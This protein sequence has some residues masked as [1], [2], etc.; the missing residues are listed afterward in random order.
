MRHFRK[1]RN[2]G[3]GVTLLLAL[4]GA[5]IAVP[6][7]AH[8]DPLAG[9]GSPA[10]NATAVGSSIQ[11][12]VDAEGTIPLA[13]PVTECQTI[14]YSATLQ[15]ITNPNATLT[16]AAFEQGRWDLTLPSGVV[17]NLL[18]QLPVPYTQIPCITIADPTRNADDPNLPGGRGACLTQGLDHI[19]SNLVPYTV[20][21]ADIDQNGFI[22]ARANYGNLIP[23]DPGTA[24]AHIGTNDIA[25]VAADTPYPIFVQRCGVSDGCTTRGCDPTTGCFETPVVC[26]DQNSCTADTCDPATGCVFTP[27]VCNDQNACTADTCDPATGCV[28]TPIV[29]NDHNACTTDTCDPATGCV[30]TPNPPCNDQNACTTDTC[31]PATG[32]V[33]TPNPPCNDQNA[34]TTDTCDPAT[35][36][37]FTPNP[38]CNDQNAC[39]TDTCDPATGCV[40]TP[41]VCDDHN[42]C[43]D[44][45]CDPATGCF[46]HCEPEGKPECTLTIGDFIWNDINADGLQTGESSD[47][48]GGV[49]L[50]LVNCA[51]NDTQTT[52]T[53]AD[54]SYLFSVS[55]NPET[56]VFDQNYKIVVT[57]TGNVL[58][59]FTESPANVGTDDTIDSDCVDR[60]IPCQPYT[61]TDLTEDCGFHKPGLVEVC[62]TPGFWGTHAGVE[63]KNSQNITQAVLDRAGG[64]R[65]CGQLIDNTLPH[66]P[67]LTVT[68]QES[69]VEAICVAPRGAQILQLARQL[70]AAALNC[71]MSLGTP[72]PDP[73]RI[74][75][76]TNPCGGVSI[77]DLWGQ[78]DDLCAQNGSMVMNGM[79]V[80]GCIGAL[81]CF[82]NGGLWMDGQCGPNP[83]GS[84]HNRALCQVDVTGMPVPGGLC[85]EPPGAAGSS[86]ACN[87]ATVNG[88]TIFGG[89]EGRFPGRSP[90]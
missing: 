16:N 73:D 51:T 52:T 27:I 10:A 14:Y 38:P 68:S 31:D 24:Y 89:C 62:R 49:T 47:G 12:F 90:F 23:T 29:C 34:C 58:E 84:C 61:S 26:N 7:W 36:C 69:A 86:D 20:N 13:G 70:T 5:G 15:W 66:A 78:C 76:D 56:C 87:A 80:T 46:F 39:T 64:L 81:D 33:F 44:D 11:V 9:G 2:V 77:Q 4:M 40:F 43:T 42:G 18:T 75:A 72:V 85:F 88:C 17:V 63:K 83:A 32:C 35:G 22:N 71:V 55:V 82:N 74:Q 6:A 28:F 30:F 50:D 60:Q 1:G 67:N 53:A 57:D 19:T 54:G 48:I 79:S 8:T 45:G 37:V 21:I 59:G 65:V 25:G 41:I 3:G